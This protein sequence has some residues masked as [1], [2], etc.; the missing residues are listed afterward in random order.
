MDAAH[1]CADKAQHNRSASARLD[2]REDRSEANWKSSGEPE[3]LVPTLSLGEVAP[4]KTSQPLFFETTTTPCLPNIFAHPPCALAQHFYRLLIHSRSRFRQVKWQQEKQAHPC[5]I[6]KIN[7]RR[8]GF[9]IERKK[10]FFKPINSA[11]SIQQRFG[12][13]GIAL[14]V[15]MKIEC[16]FRRIYL[17]RCSDGSCGNNPMRYLIFGNAARPFPQLRIISLLIWF[18]LIPRLF[19]LSFKLSKKMLP[20]CGQLRP[21]HLKWLHDFPFLRLP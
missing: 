4:D 10:S 15:W 18:S 19:V 5:R 20:L 6:F 9:I 21:C 2:R 13:C 3:P 7:A 14:W 11:I 8:R 12:K 16:M 1:F 17:Q